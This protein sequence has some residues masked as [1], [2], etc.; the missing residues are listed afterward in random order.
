[1]SSD[2]DFKWAPSPIIFDDLRCGEYYDARL[3]QP[4][5][6]EPGFDDS[7]WQYT[8]P[9][10]RPAGEAVLCK[11]EPVRCIKEIFPVSKRI[12]D[13]RMLFDFGINTT[14]VCRLK[15][16]GRT[17]QKITLWHGETLVGG[18]FYNRN[19][20]TPD[21]DGN[22]AQKDILICSGRED[23]FEPRFTYHGFRYVFVEGIYP[24]DVEEDF[25]VLCQMRQ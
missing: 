13:G 9:A 1:M 20:Y 19:T 25:L 3:E 8:L 4:G 22:L 14:G 15:Y 2:T 5:F 24:Y 21:F 6:S 18:T 23:V 16:K 12:S 11:A 7:D 10:E 17:G